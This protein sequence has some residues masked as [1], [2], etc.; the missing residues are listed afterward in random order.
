MYVYLLISIRVCLVLSSHVVPHEISSVA[1]WQ[2]GIPS[3]LSLRSTQ[4]PLLH[5]NWVVA[6]HGSSNKNEAV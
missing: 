5:V 3:H 4:K 2:S 6:L 1:S